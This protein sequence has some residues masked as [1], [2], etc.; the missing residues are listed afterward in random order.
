MSFI[1]DGFH[2]LLYECPI[3]P[4][5]FPEINHHVNLCGPIPAGEF[6]LVAH[7]LGARIAMRKTNDGPDGYTTAL[8]QLGRAFHRVGLDANGS[9]AVLG[10]QPTSLVQILIGHGRMKKRMIDH[11]GDLDVAV[12]HGQ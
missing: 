4:Q 3:A 11:L 1:T 10:R 5:R 2:I 12:F 7:R 6:G 8:E 9:H